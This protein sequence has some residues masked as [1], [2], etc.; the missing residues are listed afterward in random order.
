MPVKTVSSEEGTILTIS[1]TGRFDITAHSDFIQAYKDKLGSVAKIVVD[2]AAVEYIDSSALGM[3]L[4][5]REKAGGGK[6]D[7]SLLNCS[8]DVKRIIRT[9]HFDKMFHLG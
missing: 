1:V 5:L 3:L 6:S 2:L 9:V 4:I 8:P 7:I